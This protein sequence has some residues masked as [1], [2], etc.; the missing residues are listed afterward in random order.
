M[1]KGNR[2]LLA[3][4]EKH[5]LQR[6]VVV[7][8]ATGLFNRKGYA[9]T[10]M[11][12][13]ARALKISRPALY[14]YFVNKEDV[15]TTLVKEVT[16][17]LE[18][19]GASSTTDET[20][21]PLETLHEMIRNNALFVLNNVAKFRVVE[22]SESDLPDDIRQLNMR[23]KRGIYDR[24]RI[25]IERGIKSGHFRPVDPAVAAFS[26][27]GL[28][29]WSAWW[30]KPDG[31]LSAAEVADQIAA[32]GLASVRATAAPHPSQPPG[33]LNTSEA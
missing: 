25:V 30:F 29:S 2:K 31:S 1:R 17:H 8:A 27:I 6:R 11:L 14:H 3:G 26:I 10:S 22:H 21:D 23:A 13:V 16:L 19:L 33:P 5:E 32:M 12:D 18:N 20:R 24:F 9:G 28:C 4:L 7:D 15:L